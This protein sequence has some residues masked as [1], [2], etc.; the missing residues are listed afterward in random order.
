MLFVWIQSVMYVYYVHI[1]ISI[2]LW[3]WLCSVI[4]LFTWPLV[5]TSMMHTAHNLHA[6]VIFAK[7]HIILS[8]CASHLITA[9]L[10]IIYLLSVEICKYDMRC[11]CTTH[12]TTSVV[13][14]WFEFQEEKDFSMSWKCVF[15]CFCWIKYSNGPRAGL[16]LEPR[17]STIRNICICVVTSDKNVVCMWYI[18]NF[19]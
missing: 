8:P 3:R 13:E 17:H 14:K 19:Y 5:H 15:F 2:T 7:V 4:H 6:C 9:P 10:C 11:T 12:T 1:S 18:L 16:T